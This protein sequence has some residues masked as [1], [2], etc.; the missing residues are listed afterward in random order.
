[1]AVEYAKVRE[2]FGRPI[3]SFQAIKHHCAEM[4]V[5]AELAA[6]GAWDATRDPAPTGPASRLAAAVAASQALPGYQRC[7]ERNLQVHGG[8]GYTWE[9][10]AHLHLRRAVSVAIVF[11]GRAAAGEVTRLVRQGAATDRTITLPAEAEQYRAEARAF[12][13]RHD[14]LPVAERRAALIDSGYFVPHWPTPWGRGAGAAEQLV[15]E[16]ELAGV[17][18]PDLGIGTWVLPTLLQCATPEQIGRWIRPS[19]DGDLRWCQL[20]SEPNAGSDA[21]AIS[22]RGTRVDGGWLVAG[23]KVWTS[24]AVASNVGLMT[25]RT[26][27]EAPKHRGITMMALDM[28]APG[29]EIRPLREITGETLFNEVFIDDVFV[30]DDDVVGEVDQGWAVARATLGSERVSIGANTAALDIIDA[31]ELVE[32]AGVHA[33]AD[34]GVDRDVGRLFAEEH[35]MASLNLRHVTR[36]L[37]GGPPG[38]EG[39]VTKLLSAEHAQRVA[40]AAMRHRRSASAIAG[41]D[42]RLRRNYLFTRCLTIAGGTSE[43]TRNVIAERLLGLPRDPLAR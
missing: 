38:P 22:T 12:R 23:Q 30:P 8:I 27:P 3:G 36:A 37:I 43:I 14:A 40:A 4:L 20:F 34:A 42:A 15:I 16:E 35:A 28:R 5:D 39:N 19:L 9:H 10:D 29:V 21:A 18:Q 1:M 6:A 24:D 41:E 25:V 2:Q 33:P 32:L 7:A 31:R 26:D 17:E 11:D 13:A